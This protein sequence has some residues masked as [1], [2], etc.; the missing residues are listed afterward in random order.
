[1]IQKSVRRW[2]GFAIGETDPHAGPHT[3]TIKAIRSNAASLEQCSDE[4]LRQKCRNLQFEA[5]AG[6]TLKD[7]LVPAFGLACATIE[8]VTGLRPF[9]TQVRAGIELCHP[10]IVEMATGEGKT[11]TA[12]MPVFLKSLDRKGLLFATSN[13]YL[14]QRDADHAIEVFS[15]LG[16]SVGCIQSESEDQQRKIAYQ[17]D[18]TYGTITQFG[19]D[20]LRDRA[21]KKFNLQHGVSSE[22]EPV[23]RGT[24][25]AIIADEADGALI[26]EAV[27]PMLIASSPTPIPD[28]QARLYQWADQTAKQAVPT[29]HY[30][31]N[32]LKEKMELSE[33]GRTWVRQMAQ[34]LKIEKTSLLDLFEYVERAILVNVDYVRDK[35]FIVQGGKI[36]MV[37]ENTGRL[38][39]G[40]EWSEGMQQAIQAKE[41]LTITGQSGQLAKV[42]VQNFVRAFKHRSGM[43]GTATQSAREFKKI[44]KLKVK[45]IPTYRKSLRKTLRELAFVDRRQ[46][47]EAAAK[48]VQAMADLG[49]PV[50]VGTR[51]IQISEEVAEVFQELG[52]DHTLL[53]AKNDAAEADIISDAGQTGKVT[54]AT[55]MAGRG[56]DIKLDKISND[57]GGLH[58]VVLGLQTS[59]RSDRQLF[60]RCA[61]QGDPGSYRVIHFLDDDLLDM[62]WGQV[63]AEKKREALR[64]PFQQGSCSAVMRHAQKIISNRS[65]SN[66]G[67]MLYQEKKFVKKLFNAGLDPIL[68]V[69]G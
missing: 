18:V 56:T 23:G 25:N 21:K 65:E 43:T 49:R 26:D 20:F 5:M 3:A 61:R 60:G 36:I 40:R 33:A 52:V 16:I 50:L 4:E 44:Y 29:K 63:A 17:C 14:A 30:Q 66:R 68:D 10:C 27:T 37:D 12:L 13:D 41:D 35:K 46:A 19:F 54:I 48:E 9:P 2:A 8:R 57:A 55:N 39:I 64:N 34:S 28:F 58:V 11:L 67:A 7:L 45:P 59:K 24:L 42:S 32:T 15:R 62:A 69:P 38:G 22:S 6:A 47:F 31:K 51:T 53:N 1:M